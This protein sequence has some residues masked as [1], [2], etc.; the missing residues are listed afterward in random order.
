MGPADLDDEQPSAVE[1][2]RSFEPSPE[3]HAAGREQREIVERLLEEVCK[4]WKDSV[5]ISEYLIGNKNAK[6]ISESYDMS[7]DLVYQRARRLR[8]RLVKWLEERGIT[9]AE[10]LLASRI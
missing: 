4:D 5:I 7:E 9:S 3:A 2:A 8:L 6:E 10:L 1:R